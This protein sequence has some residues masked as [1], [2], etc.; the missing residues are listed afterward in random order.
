MVVRIRLSKRTETQ[1]FRLEDAALATAA[2]LTP[3][4]L[5]AFTMSFWIL[6][7]DLRWTGDFF[8]SHG[9]FSHWQVWLCIAGVLLLLARLLDR[10]ARVDE[11]YSLSEKQLS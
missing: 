11:E 6:A 9:L 4:A 2:L 10:F 5:L 1:S 8:L 3:S 7:S